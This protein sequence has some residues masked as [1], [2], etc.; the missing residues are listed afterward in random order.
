MSNEDKN[1]L[2][3]AN[4]EYYD[5]NLTNDKLIQ[6]LEDELVNSSKK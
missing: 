4:R 3:V 5:K 1:K 6:L 2:G